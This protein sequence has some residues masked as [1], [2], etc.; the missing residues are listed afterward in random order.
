M[1]QEK[2]W[3][4]IAPKWLEFR[5]K[6]FAFVLNFV[7][8]QKGRMLDLGCGTGRFFVKKR[9][10]KIYAVDFSEKMLDYAENKV[11]KEE[12]PIV[13]F[14]SDISK[15]PFE[16]DFFDSAIFIASLHCLETARKRK[17]TLKE[18]HRVLKPGA[19]A[20]ITTWSKNNQRLKNKQKEDYIPW[21][22]D[23]KRVFRFNYIYDKDELNDLLG[24]IGFNVLKIEEG[25][26]IVAVVEK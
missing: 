12:I 11:V 7:K 6:P 16:N 18:L 23:S 24:D 22:I 5:K 17:Q 8:M 9:N 1:N 19:K 4:V 10:L 13:L 2:V 26:N 15:L 14:K 20:M 3:D 21:T 25:L